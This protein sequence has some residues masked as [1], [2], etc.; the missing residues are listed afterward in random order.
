MALLRVHNLLSRLVRPS[1]LSCPLP[2]WRALCLGGR[3]IHLVHNP[4]PFSLL[5]RL[6]K[7]HSPIT[8]AAPLP[9]ATRNK[10][11]DAA[12]R[13]DNDNRDDIS[14][15]RSSMSTVNDWIVGVQR[16]FSIVDTFVSSKPEVAALVWGGIRFLIEVRSHMFDG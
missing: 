2:E 9:T 5:A 4:Q 16:Y 10:A 1:A 6:S 15:F 13:L 12:R 14:R 3:P 7:P 8:S 11:L